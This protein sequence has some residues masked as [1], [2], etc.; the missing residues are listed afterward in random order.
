[1]FSVAFRWWPP[2]LILGLEGKPIRMAR[3]ET[4]FHSSP[5]YISDFPKLK[6]DLR[7][8]ISLCWETLCPCQHSDFF[9]FFF[10]QACVRPGQ[11]ISIPKRDCNTLFPCSP[12]AL[13]PLGHVIAKRSFSNTAADWLVTT[14][15]RG[16]LSPSQ[17]EWFWNTDIEE[18]PETQIC[19]SKAFTYCPWQ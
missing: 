5:S 6:M 4:R 15:I 16:V 3:T 13:Q 12:D 18:V 2:K 14:L 19:G 7:R 9:F 1:M 8:K 17:R 10:S 11:K